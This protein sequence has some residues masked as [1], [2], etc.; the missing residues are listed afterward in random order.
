M[1]TLREGERKHAENA[2]K[3][4]KEE[5]S[6][7]SG[8]AQ[9]EYPGPKL[10]PNLS[11]T[12]EIEAQLQRPKPQ[13]SLEA[14]VQLNQP[15]TRPTVQS[16][17][18]ATQ[19]LMAQS[20]KPRPNNQPDPVA[21]YSS[22]LELE[23][24]SCLDPTRIARRGASY[25]Y[26]MAHSDTGGPSARLG[27]SQRLFGSAPLFSARFPLFRPSRTCFRPRLRYPRPF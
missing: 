17:R 4:G 26:H 12:R 1:K 13:T 20:S 7:G 21:F 22:R 6:I 19:T 18:P 11:P 5:G 8:S 23:C 9:T 16:N 2:Q 14:T 10:K 25:F 27:G 15:E 24:D 3:S